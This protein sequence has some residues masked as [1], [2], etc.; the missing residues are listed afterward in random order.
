MW[1]LSLSDEKRLRCEAVHGEPGCEW[2]A[3][4]GAGQEITKVYIYKHA[5]NLR[6]IIHGNRCS[7]EILSS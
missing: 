2:H 1:M 3:S 6:S 5:Y 4:R 7:K